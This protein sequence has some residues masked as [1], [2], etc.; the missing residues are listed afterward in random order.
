[1][2][3]TI[4]NGTAF[5]DDVFGRGGLA[6]IRLNE[7]RYNHPGYRLC[8]DCSLVAWRRDSKATLKAAGIKVRGWFDALS[9]EVQTGKESVLR[10]EYNG[11]SLEVPFDEGP[12]WNHNGLRPE[13]VAL[14][15][16]SRS[17]GSVIADG[18][19]G[20]TV[21]EALNFVIDTVMCEV[22]G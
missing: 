5:N 17:I 19:W 21:A 11:E 18:K 6:R 2:T 20:E 1:M 13:L 3:C 15:G 22:Y 7:C 14:G 10:V 12:T 8:D 4:C 9:C 16:E